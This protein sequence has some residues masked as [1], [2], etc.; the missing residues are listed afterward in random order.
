MEGAEG[1]PA[2]GPLRS[3]GWERAGGRRAAVRFVAPAVVWEPRRAQGPETSRRPWTLSLS[4]P[5]APGPAGGP[6]LPPCHRL[7][8]HRGPSVM[9][10]SAPSARAAA[11]TSASGNL[12]C[13]P[14]CPASFFSMKEDPKYFKQLRNH[15]CYLT[16]RPV[17]CLWGL[18]KFKGRGKKKTQQFFKKENA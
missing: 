2:P 15:S 3:Y 5:R 1:V 16:S 18:R 17:S 6:A 4:R 14:F 10:A 12:L 11:P 9:Q 13:F 7:A 8:T